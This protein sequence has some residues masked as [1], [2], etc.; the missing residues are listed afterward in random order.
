MILKK[1]TILS[2]PFAIT[3]L[4]CDALKFQELFL[5]QQEMKV[6]MPALGSLYY[7]TPQIVRIINRSR[8]P[9]AVVTD[10]L[11]KRVE[12]EWTSTIGGRKSAIERSVRLG[13]ILKGL[14]YQRYPHQGESAKFWHGRENLGSNVVPMGDP[15]SPN[16]PPSRPPTWRGGLSRCCV[17]NCRVNNIL[18]SVYYFFLVNTPWLAAIR[19][20][21]E[22]QI[23]N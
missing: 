3:Q 15:K 7:L 17:L 23:Q 19:H 22:S 18:Y 8:I 20:S 1:Q 16:S 9:G 6:A 2:L 13:A 14:G 12:K 11:R 5:M 4:G 10:A 21:G